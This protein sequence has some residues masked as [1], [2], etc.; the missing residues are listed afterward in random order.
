MHDEVESIEKD[1]TDIITKAVVMRGKIIIPAFSVERTQEMI[2]ILHK[3]RNKKKI[4][5]LPIYVDSPLATNVTGVF[6]RH[7]EE[8]DKETFQDFIDNKE[9][10]FGFSGLTYTESQ[11]ESRELNSAPGPFIIISAS[12]MCDH[13]RVKHHIRN[14]ID[15]ESNTILLVGFMAEGT[16][17]RKL[18]DKETIITIFGRRYLRKATVKIINALSGHADQKELLEYLS[19]I[20]EVSHM[21]LVHGE[22]N[23]QQT[24]KEYL[25]EA[26]VADNIVIPK[27]GTTYEIE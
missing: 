18:A 11:E 2:Y 5:R 16:L 10:P 19:N 8:Y 27:R 9:S 26:Q 21:F 23:A 17:G 20:K 24:L 25:T 4:P 1:I 6:G 3:L 12:G 22:Y 13:G 15:D 14:T 7:M